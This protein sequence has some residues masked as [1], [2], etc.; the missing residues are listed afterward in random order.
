MD[1][2]DG[3]QEMEKTPQGLG[4]GQAAG[5]HT[6]NDVTT[7]TAQLAEAMAVVR[8]LQQQNQAIG[9]KM[10]DMRAQ[11]HEERMKRRRY[12]SGEQEARREAQAHSTPIDRSPPPPKRQRE[13]GMEEA[14]EGAT[15]HTT[16]HTRTGNEGISDK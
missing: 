14:R 7:L 1:T 9:A 3:S 16:D 6:T 8:A 4:S 10:R 13:P 12:L 11:M 15:G 5:T 2:T